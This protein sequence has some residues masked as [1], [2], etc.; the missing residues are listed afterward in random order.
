MND[1]LR[2]R[3]DAIIALLAV[4][5]FL[6]AGIT[7]AVGGGEVLVLLLFAGTLAALLARVVAPDLRERFP[8]LDHGAR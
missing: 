1:A 5:V 6:L 2:K 7:V 8:I 3:L 4:V